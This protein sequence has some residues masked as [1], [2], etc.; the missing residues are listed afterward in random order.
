MSGSSSFLFF[1][2]WSVRLHHFF[3]KIV[4]QDLSMS[5]NPERYINH[6]DW[7]ENKTT[8]N[9]NNVSSY[10]WTLMLEHSKIW[11]KNRFPNIILN[12]WT[13]LNAKVGK[14]F[15]PRKGFIIQRYKPLNKLF[16]QKSR[17]SLQFQ[18]YERDIWIDGF[19]HQIS[20]RKESNK[21]FKRN[22]YFFTN[23]SCQI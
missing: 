21:L 18:I 12:P 6:R 13:M 20:L 9:C 3:G 16:I 11:S 8:Q 1:W 23:N 22:N 15:A 7:S 14:G 17:C 19:L 2:S 5:F 4:P 10:S